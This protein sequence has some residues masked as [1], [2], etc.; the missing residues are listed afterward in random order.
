MS[1]GRWRGCLLACLLPLLALPVAPARA[2]TDCS[3]APPAPS[4][5]AEAAATARRVEAA[6]EALDEPVL[7]LSRAGTDLSAYGLH[8]SHVAFVLR[9]HPDGR[10]TVLHLLNECGSNRS[11]IYAQGLVNFFM[12]G[13]VSQDAR[14]TRLDP[15]LSSQLAAQLLG[16]ATL[17]LHQPRYSVISPYG[18][19]ASQN[20]TAWVLDQLSAARVGPDADRR[21]AKRRQQT[22]GFRPDRL[23]IPYRKRVLGGLFA[24]NADF[25]EHPVGTR[26]SGDYP[27]VTVR[28]ILAHLARLGL[29]TGEWEWRDGVERRVPGPA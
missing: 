14:L 27:V 11:G 3:A 12:D 20:S 28:A 17:R 18:S 5:V 9:D 10:W 23:H 13:L 15:A 16:T 24:A 7:L 19:L 22:D 4:Q 26:L 29:S 25:G 1:G 2:G 8:Y 21:A 6:L